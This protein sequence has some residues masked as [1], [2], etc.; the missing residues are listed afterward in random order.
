MICVDGTLGWDLIIGEVKMNHVGVCA[1]IAL[2]TSDRD[3]LVFLLLR[4]E[5]ESSWYWNL[6]LEDALVSNLGMNH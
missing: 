4:F 5:N 6:P 1:T 2:L 3:T